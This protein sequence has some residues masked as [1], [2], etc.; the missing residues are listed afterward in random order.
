MKVTR[1][2]SNTMFRNGR[3]R[4]EC[5]EAETTDG[6]WLFLRVEDTGAPWRLIHQPSDTDHG[7][8]PSLPKA[9]ERA[10]QLAAAI[11]RATAD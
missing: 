10:E 5:W 7:L 1:K 3:T 11:S 8:S 2:Y 4:R 9:I 6:V